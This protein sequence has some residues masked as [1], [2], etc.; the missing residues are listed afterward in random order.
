MEINGDSLTVTRGRWGPIETSDKN[1][2][3]I[4][5]VRANDQFRTRDFNN[6]SHR[7]TLISVNRHSA[8]FDERSIG[9]GDIGVIPG[10]MPP[11]VIIF[12]TV[13]V[14]PFVD[15]RTIPANEPQ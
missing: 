14:K 2:H 5:V 13:R 4:L 1:K 12:N 11:P 6:S 10:I 7:Y 3:D 15:E 8:V 9:C